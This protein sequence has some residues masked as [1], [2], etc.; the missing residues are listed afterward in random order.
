MARFGV[1][2]PLAANWSSQA[3]MARADILSVHTMAGSLAGTDGMWRKTGYS[4]S[5][6]HFGIGGYGEC[7]QWQDTMYRAAANMN[8]NHHIISVECADVGPPFPAWNLNDGNAVPAFTPDQVETL[9]QLCAAMCRAHDMPCELIPDAKPGRR[10]IGYHRL[11]VP[12]YMVP[13]AEQWSTARGKVCPG[14]RRIAQ[15][16]QVITRARA[17]LGGAATTTALKAEAPDMDAAQ[18]RQ[19]ADIHGKV[20]ALALPLTGR[21]G[22]DSDDLLG[23]VLSSDAAARQALARVTDVERKLDEVLGL[24]RK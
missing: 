1:W 15:I 14:N 5:H 8:G 7:W 13:G 20:V 12:G 4:G 17:I 18:A 2:K 23:H 19:L 16:P 9:A 24:L 22:P 21:P 10:G 3:K 11:G 6:S